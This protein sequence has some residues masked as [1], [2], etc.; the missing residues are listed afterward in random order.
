MAPTI[1]NSDAVQVETFLPEQIFVFHGF[2]LRANPL[3]HREQIESCAP[4]RQVRFGSLNYTADIRGDLI[5][6]GFEPLPSVPH[7]H[8][9]HDLDLPLDSTRV[10]AP[11]AAPGNNPEQTVPSEDGWMDPAAEALPLA[12]IEPNIDLSLHESCVVKLPDPSPATDSEP[13]APVSIE[14]D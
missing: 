8:D 1:I 4:G 6:H 14:F 7:W 12:A 10:I 13:P 5:F 2:A 9:E 11:A 3:G